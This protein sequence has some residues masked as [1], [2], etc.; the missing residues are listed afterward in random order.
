MLPGSGRR[1]GP[2][3]VLQGGVPLVKL[4]PGVRRRVVPQGGHYVAN[5]QISCRR[6]GHAVAL[7]LWFKSIAL[8]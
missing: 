7:G 6:P 1:L 8:A 2:K 4:T 5:L 3:G